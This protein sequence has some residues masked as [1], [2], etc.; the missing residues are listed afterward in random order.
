MALDPALLGGWPSENA[1]WAPWHAVHALGELQAWESAPAL[2][3][4]AHRENDWLSDH[5]PHI[6]ADMGAEVEPS[7]WMI[8]ED[9]SASAK[10]RGLAAD[11]LYLMTDD[12]EA[13]RL[14]LVRGFDKLLGNAQVFNP[15]V[16]AYLIHF[17]MEMDAVD[18]IFETVELAF[19]QSRV[20]LDI[21]TPEDLDEDMSD[22][23]FDEDPDIEEEE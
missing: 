23:L 14:K 4:L 5:L 12:N 20:D 22:N 6:W 19:D 15:T 2:A 18:E 13:M 21:T 1:S 8:L 16:N 17:L 11:S 7:L 9:T 3:V 10:Q